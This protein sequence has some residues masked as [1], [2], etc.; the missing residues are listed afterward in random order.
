MQGLVRE[1]W[2]SSALFLGFITTCADSANSYEHVSIT[3]QPMDPRYHKPRFFHLKF[4]SLDY[5]ENPSKIVSRSKKRVKGHTQRALDFLT[6]IT[7][8]F[9]FCFIH[10]RRTRKTNNLEPQS[11]APIP[12]NTHQKPFILC[13][14]AAALRSYSLCIAF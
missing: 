1:T 14:H 4:Q 7:L 12:N 6:P 10:C 2:Y 3:M 11:Q 8:V 5:P 9:P 13:Y